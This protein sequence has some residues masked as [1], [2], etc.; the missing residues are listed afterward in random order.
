MC[1]VQKKK[2]EKGLVT[3]TGGIEKKNGLPLGGGPTLIVRWGK[4]KKKKWSTKELGRGS[5]TEDLVNKGRRNHPMNGGKR[6]GGKHR[7]C[8]R[9]E[10]GSK[11]YLV[12]K[13]KN[14]SNQWE[15]KKP[16]GGPEKNHAHT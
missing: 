15:K 6:G 3:G 2:N 4:N 13:K 9:R 1:G 12:K 7:L 16:E 11:K 5:R 14:E 10:E 8:F